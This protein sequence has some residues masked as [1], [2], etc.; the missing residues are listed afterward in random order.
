PRPQQQAD[1]EPA[2]LLL[3]D[4]RLDVYDF[5]LTQRTRPTGAPQGA[6]PDAE[7]T[8][9]GRPG[10]VPPGAERLGPVHAGRALRVDHPGDAHL[11]EPRAHDVF[12][13]TGARKPAGHHFLGRRRAGGDVFAGGAPLV[14]GAGHALVRCTTVAAGVLEHVVSGHVA[15]LHE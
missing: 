6:S 3:V 7:A 4:E 1:V 10:L 14:A 13:M 8:A 9:L 11:P 5:L 15:R 2:D 12:A